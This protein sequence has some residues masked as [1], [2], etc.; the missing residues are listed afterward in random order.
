MSDEELLPHCDEICREEGVAFM[1]RLLDE[2]PIPVS[3]YRHPDI[4]SRLRLFGIPIA[5]TAIIFA[6]LGCPNGCDF[7][8]TSHFY[9]EQGR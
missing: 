4:R 6:G 7:C 2:P 3:E 5:H 8:S 9:E 1:R